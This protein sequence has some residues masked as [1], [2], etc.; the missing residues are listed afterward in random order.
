MADGERGHPLPTGVED[1]PLKA[2]TRFLATGTA[3]QSFVTTDL[4]KLTLS[5]VVENF[6][7]KSS[8]RLIDPENAW[9]G[10]H[11][12][13]ETLWKREHTPTMSAV[14]PI[15]I[16]LVPHTQRRDVPIAP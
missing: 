5:I 1:L 16:E 8:N 12:P 3:G 10:Q 11:A 4:Q 7:V 13:N 9:G 15:A 2:N 6:L 14:P